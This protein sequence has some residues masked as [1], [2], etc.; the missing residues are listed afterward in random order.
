MQAE[1]IPK[2]L[3]WLGPIKHLRC[4]ISEHFHFQTFFHTENT[5]VPKII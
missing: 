3:G 5:L 1:E 4:F 2:S